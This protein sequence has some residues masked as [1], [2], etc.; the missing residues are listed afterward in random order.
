MTEISGN[1]SDGYHTFNELYEHRRALFIAL[2][3]ICED[4]WRSRKHHD[5]SSLDGWFLAGIALPT[6]DISYHLPNEDWE[7]LDG[8][9]TLDA[10]RE[11]DGHSGDDVVFRLREYAKG[12]F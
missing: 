12:G 6:G 5:G 4:V 1:T 9:L 11:W 3:S 2:A 10:G 7:L 8:A